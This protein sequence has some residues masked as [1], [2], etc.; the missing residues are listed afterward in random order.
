[1]LELVVSQSPRLFTSGASYHLLG[2]VQASLNTFMH[3]VF[4]HTIKTFKNNLLAKHGRIGHVAIRTECTLTPIVRNLLFGSHH[5]SPVPPAP[6]PKHSSPQF[7]LEASTR[8][9]CST[10]R[11]WQALIRAVQTPLPRDG[12]AAASDAFFAEERTE[13]HGRQV[14]RPA[15][16]KQVNSR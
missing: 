12:L 14:G 2:H 1:M 13:A 3:F 16:T 11:W 9:T 8:T 4:M 5:E 6:W 10:R 15:T 7:S